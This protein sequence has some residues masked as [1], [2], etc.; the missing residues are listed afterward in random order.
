MSIQVT[1]IPRLTVLTTPAFTLGTANTAGSA[2]TGVASDSTLLTF[3]TTLPDAITFGQSGAVGAATVASRRDHAHAT[4]T[5]DAATQAEMEAASST[6]VFDTPGRTQYHPGVIKA[7]ADF[8][9]TGT[10]AIRESHNCTLT[11]NGT[12][13]Y[14]LTF[15]TDFANTNFAVVIS[16]RYSDYVGAQNMFRTP[17]NRAVGS[18]NVTTC[19]DGSVALDHLDVMVACFGD[20]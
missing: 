13:D 8:N 4:A 20:Q 2:I 12:G 1:P 16:S 19:N 11:D 17:Q 3:D 6:T 15:G 7:W 18:I 10:A 9:G 5:V 14:T